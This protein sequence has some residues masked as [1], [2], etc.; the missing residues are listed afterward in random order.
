METTL[1]QAEINLQQTRDSASASKTRAEQDLNRSV[2]SLTQAQSSYALALA[3]W[4]RVQD[5]GTDPINPQTDAQ[6]GKTRKLNDAQ[7]Q[8]YYDQLVQAQASLKSAE[9]AVEQNQ[10]AFGNARQQEVTQIQN[11]E[12]QVANAQQQLQA[13][14]NPSPNSI[15]QAQAS[16]DQARANLQKLQQGGTAADIEAARANVVQA[17]ANLEKLTA[18][19]TST[20]LNIQQASI[21]QAEQALK[22][23][24]LNLEQATLL[25]PFDGVVTTVN[26]VP[27]SM[28][29]SARPAAMTLVDRSTLHVDLKLS[30]NDVARVAPG[31]PVQLTIDALD[32]WKAQGEVRY[33]ALT[34]DDTNGVVTYRVRVRFPG[35]D[36][37]VKVGMTAN[38]AITTATKE[39]VLIVPNAALLP[40]GAGRV[41]QVPDGD[42]VREVEV[43]TGITDGS[44]TEIIG[45]LKQGDTIVATP[46]AQQEPS[47][48]LLP[49]P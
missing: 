35:T 1:R 5:R 15:T 29:G 39:R 25:A 37:R 49:L 27:G 19:A 8:Q 10:V 33:I 16:A 38:V 22:Q 18:P 26:I 40:K 21:A 23:A 3:N 32:N 43:Q 13:L 2:A 11:G 31:Q 47:H 28:A 36:E 34:A 4:Q 48:G 41:V 20:D 14:M 7:Q 9:L 6:T 12:V 46:G 45:G 24:Q 42:G 17:Q 44:N 30:E